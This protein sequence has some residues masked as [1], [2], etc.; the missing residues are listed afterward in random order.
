MRR[1]HPGLRLVLIRLGL[2]VMSLFIVSLVVFAATELLPGDAARAILGRANDPVRLEAL[3]VQLHL[4]RP[5]V[6]QYWLWL[7]GIFHAGLGNSLANGQPVLSQLGRRIENSFAL[8]SIV[9]LTGLPLTILIGIFAAYKKGRIFDGILSVTSMAVA[10][11]PEFVI[12]ITTIIVLSTVVFHWFPPVALVRPGASI[13]SRPEALVLPTL[14]MVI[15]TFPYVFR[16]IRASMIEVL[17]SEYVEMSRIKGLSDRRIIFVHALPNA[18]A[19]T[20]QAI[21]LT[22][23]YLA[24][25]VVVVEFIFGYP[26]I[27][28]GLVSAVIARDIPMIQYI[29]LLLASFSLFVSL[30]ADALTVL[31]TPKLRTSAWQPR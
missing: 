4:D 8:L 13:L 19:P 23:A 1:L 21:A 11:V 27:G 9:L 6:I 15:A 5:A 3:R 20:I 2:T 26:G 10:A 30:I 29:T 7:S 28:Q 25:G 16:M 24:G 22:C 17:Q 14:T 12:G 31:V 18:I